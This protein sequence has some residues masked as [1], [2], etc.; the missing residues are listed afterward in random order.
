MKLTEGGSLADRL[1]EYVGD[2]E[3]AARLVAEIA[4]AVHHAHQRGTL[5]RD[6]K[7]H[8]ILLDHE[9]HPMVTDFGLAKLAEQ[10]SGLTQSGA[11]VGT[12]G[13]MPP[14]QAASGKYVTAAADIYSLGAIL[15]AT[16]TGR[17][18][19]QGETPMETVMQVVQK[20]P[21]KPTSINSKIPLEL[22]LICLKCL[23]RDP[24]Q[25]YSS[26]AA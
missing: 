6:L 3:K 11:I 1:D 18:P 19:F 24:E 23:T 26:A 12:P 17:P 9:D 8:N 13:Y 7:P 22:E 2:H 5:H 10:D 21:P 20:D 25:R 15:F 4:H 16:L 14:E